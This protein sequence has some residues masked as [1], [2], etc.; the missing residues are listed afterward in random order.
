MFYHVIG[1]R[2][3]PGVILRRNF[4]CAIPYVKLCLTEIETSTVHRPLWT[5]VDSSSE[6]TSP[7]CLLGVAVAITDRDFTHRELEHHDYKLKNFR[8]SPSNRHTH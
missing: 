3:S 4:A 8:I 5:T 7:H 1:T 6:V 2:L